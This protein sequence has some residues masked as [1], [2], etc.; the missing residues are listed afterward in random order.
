MLIKHSL[1]AEAIKGRQPTNYCFLFPQ[2]INSEG[3][4]ERKSERESVMEKEHFWFGGVGSL[5]CSS[6]S[7]IAEII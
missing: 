6:P 3:L 5:V 7:H 1:V 4:G 2:E